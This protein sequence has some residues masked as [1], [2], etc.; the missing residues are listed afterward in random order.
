MPEDV[1]IGC[2]RTNGQSNRFGWGQRQENVIEY[3]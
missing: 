2:E 3:A 1:S